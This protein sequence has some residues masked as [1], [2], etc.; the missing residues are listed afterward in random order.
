MA[1]A[2]PV[3]SLI[4]NR[5]NKMTGSSGRWTLRSVG[6]GSIN[7]TYRVESGDQ[8][9]FC[10]IN[11]A[12]KFP[13]LFEKESRGLE[14]LSR[15]D[16]IRTPKVHD[17]FEEGEMQVLILEWI[18]EGERT[19]PFWKRFGEQLARV[20]GIKSAVYG[21]HDDNYMGSV[22]QSNSTS[23]SWSQFFSE[24]RLGPMVIRCVDKGL[25]STRDIK[26]FEE[27]SNRLESIFDK[28]APSLLHGDLWS[29]NFMCGAG[30]IP[31][32]I[33]PAVYYGHPS[34]D[35]AMTT[36]FG[37]FDARFYDAYQYHQAF[38]SNYKEQWS[39]ANLYP[40]LIHL[41]LFGSSYLSRIEHTLKK[42]N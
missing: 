3:P 12:A 1:G 2:H 11:S 23:S 41:Y 29:G 30:E 40:L 26:R 21:L 6:G 5:L 13:Q 17:S 36:L 34:V 33:D 14:L 37:G 20:H 19:G 28:S 22:P 39:I 8:V 42:F 35:L 16:I 24:Q 31:V 7:E 25:L 18:P 9:F 10:K 38:P 27:V 4:S 15:H 32:L